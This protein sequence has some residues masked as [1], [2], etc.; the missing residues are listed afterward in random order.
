MSEADTIAFVRATISSL[1]ELELLLLLE[2]APER[3]WTEDEAV[4]A[5]RA[6][7][8]AIRPAVQKLRDKGLITGLEDQRIRYAVGPF[9]ESVQALAA[10]WREKPFAVINA[11]YDARNQSLRNFSDAFKLKD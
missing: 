9:E 10:L 6:S 8:A 11:I 7:R 5:L 4:G 3:V 2:T 1:W